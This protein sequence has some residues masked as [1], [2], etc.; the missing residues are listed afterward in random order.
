[1]Q[2]GRRCW[3][4]CS[5]ACTPHPPIVIPHGM[6][7]SL[8]AVLFAAS[9][10]ILFS[11]H[12]QPARRW[13]SCLAACPWP[14]PGCSA[15]TSRAWQVCTSCMHVHVSFI[16]MLFRRHTAACL[17]PTPST[18]MHRTHPQLTV[19]FSLHLWAPLPRDAPPSHLPPWTR[20]TYSLFDS[21]Q[22]PASV[23]G[24]HLH[25][26]PATYCFRRPADEFTLRQTLHPR[27]WT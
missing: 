27:P 25:S 1:M 16:Y 9:C 2:P 6:L 20:C 4:L 5:A 8:K 7:H 22:A 11:L 12:V 19:H 17:H 15:P 24:S 26:T 21:T 14:P 10:T 3:L 18:P 13:R 23:T